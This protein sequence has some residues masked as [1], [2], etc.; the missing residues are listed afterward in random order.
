MCFVNWENNVSPIRLI[1][2]PNFAPRHLGCSRSNC[3]KWWPLVPRRE[4]RSLRTFCC[5]RDGGSQFR[6]RSSRNDHN[7][8]NNSRLR[9]NSSRRTLLNQGYDRYKMSGLKQLP[10]L[11]QW[12][13]S[14]GLYPIYWPQ[15]PPSSEPLLWRK[16]PA[17][18][19]PP[20]TVNPN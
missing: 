7:E 5:I 12:T 4:G 10:R 17:L 9:P 13:F 2:G 11:N 18:L 3:C 16:P 15:N 14:N 8:C 20:A 1:A 6:D 19:Q